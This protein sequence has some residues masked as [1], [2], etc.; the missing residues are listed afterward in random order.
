MGVGV[1]ALALVKEFFPEG[2]VDFLKKKERKS[3]R[4]EVEGRGSTVGGSFSL[5]DPSST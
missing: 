1:L 5:I 2:Q 3:Q 4:K